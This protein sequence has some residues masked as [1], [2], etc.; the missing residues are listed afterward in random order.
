MQD[1]QIR[2]LMDLILC[3]RCPENGAQESD[4]LRGKVLVRAMMGGH[5][6]V[7]WVVG[8]RVDIDP[9]PISLPLRPNPEI[10]DSP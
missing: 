1:D 5:V 10:N 9:S 6:S 7:Y 8:A 4:W 3:L 2:V